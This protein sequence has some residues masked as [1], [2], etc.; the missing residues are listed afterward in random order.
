M[1]ILMAWRMPAQREV[2]GPMLLVAGRQRQS[3]Q[4]GLVPLRLRYSRRQVMAR[5]WMD[6]MTRTAAA[7]AGGRTGLRST[8]TESCQ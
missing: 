7:L 3:P 5:R 1:T 6:C 8:T 4:A 2:A